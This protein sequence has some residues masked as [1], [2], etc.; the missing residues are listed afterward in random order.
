LESDGGQHGEDIGVVGGNAGSIVQG[1]EGADGD[2]GVFWRGNGA[3]VVLSSNS[4]YVVVGEV[5]IWP[6]NLDPSSDGDF[7]QDQAR[8]RAW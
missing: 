7:S 2:W 1:G 8:L 5:G 4:Q 3:G 6:T